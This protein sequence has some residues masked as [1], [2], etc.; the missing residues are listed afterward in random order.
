M[1]LKK[2]G[3]FISLLFFIPVLFVDRVVSSWRGFL[4]SIDELSIHCHYTSFVCL[5]EMAL[6]LLNPNDDDDD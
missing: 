1:L 6:V 5:V 3:N 2:Y 4:R